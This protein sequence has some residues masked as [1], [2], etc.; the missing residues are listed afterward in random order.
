M[1]KQ[2][3]ICDNL[4]PLQLVINI[5][6]AISVV[7]GIFVVL[8]AIAIVVLISIKDAIAI[9]VVILVICEPISVLNPVAVIIIIFYIKEAVVVVILVSCISLTVTIGVSVSP[10]GRYAGGEEEK[11]E[12][13]D[14]GLHPLIRSPACEDFIS[15]CDL[16]QGKTTATDRP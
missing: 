15:G 9:I 2:Q 3:H 10:S 12:E 13:E 7:V 4:N 8:N 6:N 11:G 1:N 16:G 5:R 14:E